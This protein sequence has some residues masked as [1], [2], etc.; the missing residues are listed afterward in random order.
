MTDTADVNL[1]LGCI[2]EDDALE[3]RAGEHVAQ[4][5]RLLVP[6]SAG[7]ELL[8][9]AVRYQ[10]GCVRTIGAAST[11]FDV[12]NRGV[13]ETAAEALDAKEVPTVFDAIHLA[14]AL[15]RGSKLHTADKRLHRTPFPTV[16]F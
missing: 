2:L 15:H 14:D 12:E 10:L 8:M 9:V 7:I 4:V 5:G 16:A 13:L 1:V 3:K 11:H 6:F